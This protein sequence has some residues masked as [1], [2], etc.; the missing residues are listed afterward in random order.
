MPEGDPGE[1]NVVE[2]VGR[3]RIGE[4]EDSLEVVARIPD[5]EHPDWFAHIAEPVEPQRGEK[6]VVLLDEG[7][8]NAW[9]GSA[10]LRGRGSQSMLIGM[11][12]LVPPV[13]G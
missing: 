12:A 3:I 6:S 9:E 5:V 4:D 8:Y 13:G 7:M 11:Q 1:E 10:L 2:Y